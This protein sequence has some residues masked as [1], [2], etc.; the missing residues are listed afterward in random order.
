MKIK[1]VNKQKGVA[2]FHLRRH[3]PWM[4]GY[5]MLLGKRINRSKIVDCGK[6]S[7][8]SGLGEEGF[9]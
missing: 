8:A 5:Y 3:A 2:V 7:R 1:D 9:T 4:R 6:M